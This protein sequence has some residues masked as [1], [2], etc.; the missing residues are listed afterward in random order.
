MLR[1]TLLAPFD[2]LVTRRLREPGDTVSVGSTILRIVDT[3][4]VYVRAS[5]DE[6]VLPLLAEDQRATIFF[7][8]AS[9][10]VTGKVTR[11]S[12]EADRQTHELFVDV[13]PDRVDQRVA[14]GQRADARIELARRTDTLRAP[15]AM[16]QRDERGPYVYI[17]RNERITIGRPQLGLSGQGYVE[18][19]GGLSEGDVLLG[20][21]K[22]GGSLAAGRRWRS[23]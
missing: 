2:G 16:V 17:D 15:L 9:A 1:A 13:T 5:V 11:I 20:P 6:T 12:W 3:S 19:L 10:P 18:V 4:Q 22:P 14:V 21:V 7:P 23:E 8:G